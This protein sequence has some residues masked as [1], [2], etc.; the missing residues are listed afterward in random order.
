MN[1]LRRAGGNPGPFCYADCR[2][3]RRYRC[4]SRG[5]DYLTHP[6]RP[7]D[8]CQALATDYGVS[9]DTVEPDTL[10]F[11]DYLEAQRLLD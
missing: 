9:V 10:A 2:T 11:L 3:R 5:A 1:Q 7:R 8:L 6:A 4:R